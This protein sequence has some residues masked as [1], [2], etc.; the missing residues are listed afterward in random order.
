MCL[1]NRID[2]LKLDQIERD[3]TKD[4]FDLIDINL[5]PLSSECNY[6]EPDDVKN[7]HINSSDL[8]T[9]H[10]NIHSIPDKLDQLKDLLY[11]LDQNKVHVDVVMICET[12]I[13]DA[14]K[15]KC[16]IPGYDIVEDHRK[17]MSR[18]GVALYVNKKLKFVERKDIS[19]FDEGKFESCFIE[20]ISKS[21]NIIVGEVYRIP[22]TNELDFIK[23][24]ENL[25]KKIKNEKKNIVIGTD[26]NLDYLKIHQ[27]ANT[28]K[29]LDLNLS[30]DLLPT[31]SKPTRI[32]HSTCTL[33]DNIYV[34]VESATNIKS[35]I[36]TTHISDHLPC[37]VYDWKY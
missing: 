29:F 3:K 6:I 16:S 8:V 34:N 13:T 9:L 2:F 24:Y 15:S 21:R 11:T 25:I 19:V 32:T 35:M 14:N 4:L 12:F 33:I 1:G 5:K 10:L 26:Q 17:N 31:I 36:L 7:Q 30:N 20:I 37:F 23:Q 22:G 18:G 28:A 27:H